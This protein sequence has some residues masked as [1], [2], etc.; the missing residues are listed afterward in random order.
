MCFNG[1]ARCAF[2]CSDR[3]SDNGLHVTFFD[4]NWNVMPFERSFPSVKKGLPQPQNYKKMIIWSHSIIFVGKKF[5]WWP[6]D[7][8]FVILAWDCKDMFSNRCRIFDSVF[9]TQPLALWNWKAG[10]WKINVCFLTLQMVI[11]MSYCNIISLHGILMDC[12]K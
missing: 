8:I 12:E 1:V 4:R 6:W 10:I 3:F 11:T 2:V 7:F 9:Y 5:Y